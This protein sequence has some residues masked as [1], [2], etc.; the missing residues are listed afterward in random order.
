[1]M[2]V[3]DEVLA[4]SE[5]VNKHIK[6]ASFRFLSQLRSPLGRATKIHLLLVEAAHRKRRIYLPR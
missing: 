6:E 1:M 5:G 4:L 2:I 3:I